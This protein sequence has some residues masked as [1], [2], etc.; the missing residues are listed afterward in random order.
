MTE[1]PDKEEHYLLRV[2][3]RTV[4]DRIRQLLREPVDLNKE[5]QPAPLELVFTSK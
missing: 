5:E 3:R 1:Y 4:A 2:Q